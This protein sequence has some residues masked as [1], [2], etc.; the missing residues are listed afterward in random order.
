MTP[1][2]MTTSTTMAPDGSLPEFFL[3][4]EMP[5]EIGAVF[6]SLIIVAPASGAVMP[7][8]PTQLKTR[9]GDVLRWRSEAPEV[10]TLYDALNIPIHIAKT[11]TQRRRKWKT[12]AYTCKEIIVLNHVYSI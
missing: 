6:D 8:L 9:L 3:L 5:A 4:P 1:T 10:V 12:H 11:G 7:T 2:T